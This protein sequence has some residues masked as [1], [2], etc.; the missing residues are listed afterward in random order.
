MDQ[1]YLFLFVVG[2]IGVIVFISLYFVDAGYGKMISDKW[3]PAI[4]NKIG[5]ILM[6]CP[7]FF[8]MLYM[9]ASSDV[10]FEL[11]YLIFFL[12]FELH[13]F[14]RSFVFPLLMK[15]NSKM[16]IVIMT[17]SIAFNLVNGYIQGYW[18]FVKAPQTELYQQLYTAS[19]LTD[20][21]FILGVIVFLSGMFINWHSD[22]IIRHLRKPGD[23]KHYLPKGG[24]YNYV[25]SANYFG[26]IVEWAGWTILTASWAGFVFFWFTC[27]NLVPRANSIYHKYEAEFAD[28][29]KQR[30]LKRV[31]P[32]IY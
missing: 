25:T 30:K 28:E 7:V 15:G 21:R 22:Y 9:W 10:R 32:F 29:F 1:F 23:S 16:P 17:M 6:E 11:P 8:V 4:N 12:L 13:Y 2:I 27:S 20:W 3:G 24:M 14:Q 26:E 19:W 31:F 18:L 5:W